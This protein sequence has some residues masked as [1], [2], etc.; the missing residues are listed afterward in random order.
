M[1]AVGTTVAGWATSGGSTWAVSNGAA[2]VGLSSSAYVNNTWAT[3]NNTTVTSSGTQTNATTNSLRFNNAGALTVSLS[4]QCYLNSGGILVTSAV[5]SSASTIAGGILRPYTNLTIF[6]NDPNGS[7]TISSTIEPQYGI[8]G[9]TKA[10][11][12]LLVL[13]GN[14]S[15][16]GETAVTGGT[17]QIGS[18]GNGANLGGDLLDDET[19]V[20]FKPGNV[21]ALGGSLSGGGSLLMSGSGETIIPYATTFTG[22]VA[23]SSGTLQF[24][25]QLPYRFMASPSVSNSG[26]LAFYADANLTYAGA[27]SGSGGLVTTEQ[28]T[29]YAHRQQHLHRANNRRFPTAR[30]KSARAA[31]ASACRAAHTA[32]A[33]WS[34]TIPMPKP[35]AER[36]VQTPWSPPAAVPIPSRNWSRPPTCMSTAAS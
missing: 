27:I 21:L 36:S 1:N 4:G 8:S 6:Q 5:G 2:V 29:L 35:T 32:A 13:T 7:L 16:T 24:G 11:P 22:P 20:V 15:I 18:N 25:K 30:C 33:R 19:N 12:G 26:T 28:R 14:A 34:S 3:S 31:A 10:G 23:I 9:I 17:L